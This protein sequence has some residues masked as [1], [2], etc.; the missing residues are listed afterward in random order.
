MNRN[1]LQTSL[2]TRR[3]S[4]GFSL[5]EVLITLVVLALGL[6][7][8][9]MLQVTNLRLT[10]S[11]NSRTVATNLAYE[12]MDDIRSNRLNAINYAGDIKAA[13]AET[14]GCTKAGATGS[15]EQKKEFACRLLAGLGS[16]ATANVAVEINNTMST[17]T[18]T[19]DW[20]DSKRWRQDD[21]NTKFTAS[22]NL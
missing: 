7:G 17:V 10:Q 21:E 8:L 3:R 9:A 4:S 22:T 13:G 2:S 6:L 15:G 11:A 16:T 18:V 14:T 1:I 19:I 5:I 20:E 12:L